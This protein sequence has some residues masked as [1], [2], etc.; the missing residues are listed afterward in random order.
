MH[1]TDVQKIA[2]L[3]ANIIISMESK[4]HHTDLIKIIEVAIK[5]GGSV[6]IEK[7][8]HHTDIEKM[9]KIAGNKLTVK[10]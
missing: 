8:N 2:E 10:I 3:G 4:I 1:Y 7:E 6:I 5:N 9:A